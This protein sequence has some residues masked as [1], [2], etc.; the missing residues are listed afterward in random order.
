MKNYIKRLSRIVLAVLIAIT[1]ATPVEAGLQL[2][3]VY[4]ALKNK[5]GLFLQ[6]AKPVYETLKR[7][8]WAKLAALATGA[9]CLYYF[10]GPKKQ[11]KIINQQNCS[12][13]WQKAWAYC[14]GEHNQDVF[15][16]FIDH[17]KDEKDE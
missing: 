5:A 11:G 7:N 12:S 10:F 2:K 16:Q 1:V 3:S 17:E 13:L 9:G 8:H 14:F 6:S 15:I 4:E